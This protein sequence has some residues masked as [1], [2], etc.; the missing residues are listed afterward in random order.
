M[1]YLWVGIGGF[2]GANARYILGRL[3]GHHLGPAFPWSTALVNMSGAFLI[4]IIVTILTDRGIPDPMWRQL[5]V[6][7]F[8]GGYTTFSSYTIEAITMIQEGR[9][10]SALG[11]ILGSNVLGLL[12]CLGGIWVARFIGIMPY[13]VQ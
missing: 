7:G 10:L 8:L 13:A 6:V 4:G 2:V 9:W 5:V 1:H 11:Y 3:I 12:A